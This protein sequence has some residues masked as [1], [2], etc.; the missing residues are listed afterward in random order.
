M[1][2]FVDHLIYP[3]LTFL[4]QLLHILSAN[5][6]NKRLFAVFCV[7]FGGYFILEVWY[8]LKRCRWPVVDIYLSP[9][10]RAITVYYS[11]YFLSKSR[12]FGEHS[13]DSNNQTDT[14]AYSIC[15]YSGIR[16]INLSFCDQHRNVANFRTN[17][18]LQI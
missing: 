4:A 3:D 10:L 9:P 5:L 16:P 17:I 1:I 2:C 8:I 6:R 11:R 12:M 13:S 15:S 18:P 7:N 14:R